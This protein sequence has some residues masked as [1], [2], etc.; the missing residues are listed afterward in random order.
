MGGGEDH[1]EGP[2]DLRPSTSCHIECRLTPLELTLNMN[3]GGDPMY[4][5]NIHTLL[6]IGYQSAKW[7]YNTRTILSFKPGSAAH[8]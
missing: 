1:R 4:D 2:Y 5:R 7:L 8:R 3:Q 6:F